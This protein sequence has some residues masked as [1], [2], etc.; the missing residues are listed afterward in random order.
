SE[1]AVVAQIYGHMAELRSKFT[2]Q[3]IDVIDKQKR[4]AMVDQAVLE[5]LIKETMG[6]QPNTQSKQPAPNGDGP[7]KREGISRKQAERVHAGTLRSAL[8]LS[9]GGIRS[10]TFNLG[11]LQGLARHG[12][13]EKFDYLSTV[14]GGGFIGGWL[15]AW[16]CREG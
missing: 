3:F 8:Y 13:L 9:G 7:K 14:S 11:I 5:T 1:R 16:I 6:A 15:S 12:I 4:E 10:A 2:G